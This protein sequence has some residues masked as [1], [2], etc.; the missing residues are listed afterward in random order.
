MY[1]ALCSSILLVSL[2]TKCRYL[3]ITIDTYR[4][5]NCFRYFSHYGS[6]IFVNFW[7]F[8]DIYR[9]SSIIIEGVKC[10]RYF[11]RCGSI[12]FVNFWCFVDIYRSSS[13]II[14]GVKCLRYF[15]RCGSIIFVSHLKLRRYLSIWFDKYRS[16]N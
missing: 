11:S 3:S 16:F 4:R 15:S 1:F 2:L 9:S 8:V 12:I 10:L 7:S 5:W 14:E 13:I 6:N